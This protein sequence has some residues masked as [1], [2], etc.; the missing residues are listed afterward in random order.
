M[1]DEEEEGGR[2]RKCR[3]LDGTEVRSLNHFLRKYIILK[4]KLPDT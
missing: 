1:F 4:I 2:G 3:V